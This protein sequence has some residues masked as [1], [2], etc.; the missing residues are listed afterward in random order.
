MQQPADPRSVKEYRS[1]LPPYFTINWKDNSI[2]VR[3]P[4]SESCWDKIFEVIEEQGLTSLNASEFSVA[5]IKRL[6]KRLTKIGCGGLTDDQLL[7]LEHMP[8]LER[9]EIGNWHSVITDRGLQVLRYLKNLRVFEMVWAQTVTD[10]GLSNL[11]NCDL[12]ENVNLHGTNSGDGVVKALTGKNNLKYFTA[13][14]QVTDAGIEYL[15]QYPVFKE[16][17]GGEIKYSMMGYQAKP[18]HLMLGGTYTDAGLQ[19]LK[20]LDGLFGITFLGDRSTIGATGIDSLKALPRLGFLSVDGGLCTDAVM[21]AIGSIPNLRML[22]AQGAVATD[23]GFAA[24]AQSQSIEYIWGKDCPNLGSPGFG[25]LGTM[26]ALRGLAVSCKLVDDEALSALPQF[27][28][29]KELMPMD[30]TDAGFRHIGRCEQLEGLQCMYCRETT[31][32]ATEHIAGLQHLKEYYAGQTLITDKSL[33]MLGRM[34]SLE[35]ARFWN[36]SGITP[37]GVAELVR[38]PKLKEVVFDGCINITQDATAIFPAGVEVNYS[39]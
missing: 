35:V 12:L 16:W 13:G 29:L 15:Q 22:L 7:Q 30:V 37:K 27:P 20:G 31:D 38:L 26:P 36:I 32:V 5:A 2:S 9:L 33:G 25:A 1:V 14:M 10:Q 18:N 4:Q 21:A 28:A 11:V 17:Q 3:G 6:P 34:D 19:K 23:E 8:Q 24:L 39:A